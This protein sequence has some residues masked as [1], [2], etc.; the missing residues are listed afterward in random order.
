MAKAKDIRLDANG[1]SNDLILIIRN[2]FKIIKMER[3][4]FCM[5]RWYW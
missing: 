2:V 4:F 5:V 1:Y 3:I